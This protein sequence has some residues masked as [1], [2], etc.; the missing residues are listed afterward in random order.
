MA[1][2]EVYISGATGENAALVNG[3]YA[4]MEERHNGRAL[5]QCM[6]TQ[7]WLRYL[8]R[9]LWAVSKTEHKVAN[10]N[11]CWAHSVK[12]DMPLPTDTIAWM[13]FANGTWAEA[14]VR[15][16][17]Q[18][19]GKILLFHDFLNATPIN[20]CIIF[21]P[22]FCLLSIARPA[23]LC[24]RLTPMTLFTTSANNNILHH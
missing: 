5:Y 16:E 1:P 8:P 9:G 10:N 19:N 20:A 15:V 14:A 13:L 6:V 11:L 21:A 23:V 4:L 2:M 22:Y 12:K 24:F 18:V 7:Q 17:N 3:L